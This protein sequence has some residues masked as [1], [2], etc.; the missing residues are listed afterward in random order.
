MRKYRGTLAQLR[1]F[2]TTKGLL[3]L[4]EFKVR[5]VRQFRSTWSDGPLS[6]TKKIERL[7]CFFRYAKESEWIEQ[8]P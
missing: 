3:A 7:R 4:S 5:N 2:A 1:A 6:A 8:N